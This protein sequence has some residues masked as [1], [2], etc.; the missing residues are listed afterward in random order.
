MKNAKHCT[1]I[2]SKDLDNADTAAINYH[3]KSTDICRLPSG[4]PLSYNHSQFIMKRRG[5]QN[6]STE[7]CQ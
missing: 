5:M 2:I 7:T 4:R 1:K 3:C 6:I